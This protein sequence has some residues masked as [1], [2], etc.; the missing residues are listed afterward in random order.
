MKWAPG[1]QRRPTQ[2]AAGTGMRS[3]RSTFTQ[4]RGCVLSYRSLKAPRIGLW[5]FVMSAQHEWFIMD[6]EERMV[7]TTNECCGLIDRVSNELIN[8]VHFLS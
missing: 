4:L 7:M 8:H 3:R 6:R 1:G 5:L 2:T